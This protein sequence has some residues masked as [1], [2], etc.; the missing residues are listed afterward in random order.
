MAVSLILCSGF[1][2]LFRNCLA[3]LPSK[4][5]SEFPFFCVWARLG[6]HRFTEAMHGALYR[7]LAYGKIGSA[8]GIPHPS[9]T[10]T[11]FQGGQLPSSK[12]WE[13]N[14]LQ[15]GSTNGQLDESL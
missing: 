1:Q 3:F 8:S 12:H 6:T 14:E 13:G 2:G 4:G 10:L 15:S 7:G 9:L 5:G 11:L